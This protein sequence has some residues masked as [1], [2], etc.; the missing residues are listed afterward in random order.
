MICRCEKVSRGEI[1]DAIHRPLGARTVDG[2]RRRTRA[3][4]GRCQGGFCIPRII[5]ILSK[6][7]GVPEEQVVKNSADAQYVF[8]KLK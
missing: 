2:V 1:L 3:S 7:L 8:G 6:E 4:G 5:E